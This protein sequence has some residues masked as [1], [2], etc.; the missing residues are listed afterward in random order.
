M[1]VSLDLFATVAYDCF[2]VLEFVTLLYFTIFTF[3]LE[4]EV[5]LFFFWFAR[6]VYFYCASVCTC[7]ITA[8]STPEV[9]PPAPE[10]SAAAHIPSFQKYQEMYERSV[11][12]P[13]GE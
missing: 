13:S 1:Q 2:N 10:V 3:D 9:F 8:M 11:R 6:F 4:E 5:F 7:Y 12:E